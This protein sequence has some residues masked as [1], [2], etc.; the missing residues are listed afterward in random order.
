VSDSVTKQADDQIKT[1][2]GLSEQVVQ[3]KNIELPPLKD[4]TKYQSIGV[5]S[6]QKENPDK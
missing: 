3:E 5:I 1:V 2:H 6:P 4:S